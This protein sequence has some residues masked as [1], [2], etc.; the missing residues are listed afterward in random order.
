MQNHGQQQLFFP[1]GTGA[2]H[3]PNCMTADYIVAKNCSDFI[4]Q[5][6]LEDTKALR[7]AIAAT[8]SNSTLLKHEFWCHTAAER[9]RLHGACTRPCRG[10]QPC[11]L[12][13]PPS[14]RRMLQV[15][16]GSPP[17]LRG[18]TSTSPRSPPPPPEGPFCFV[19]GFDDALNFCQNGMIVTQQAFP[20]LNS[21]PNLETLMQTFTCSER[22]TCE[23]MVQQGLNVALLSYQDS[24]MTSSGV[25]RFSSSAIFG[26]AI[27]LTMFV[28]F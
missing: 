1:S 20:T 23:Y 25:E 16:P 2:N 12:P 17:S 9:V 14:G 10:L 6:F 27:A 11:L 28:G 18:P 24:F 22:P 21:E 19:A 8:P 5:L 7:E 15:K 4:L 26:F 3:L 13:P